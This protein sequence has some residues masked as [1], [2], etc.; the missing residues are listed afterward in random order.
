MSAVELSETFF[1]KMAGWEAMKQARS[2][3]AADRVLSSNWTPPLLKGVV[4]SGE[5]TY[6]SGFVIQSER[7]VENLCPCRESRQWGKIC[8]HSVAVGLH[9]LQPPS[10]PGPMATGPR[11][12]EKEENIPWIRRG[13]DADPRLEL[14]L[15]LPP[16]LEA[17]LAR[18]RLMICL[19]AVLQGRRL[20]LP[21]VPEKDAYQVEDAD[22]A[23]LEGLESIVG[24]QR[25]AGWQLS[26]ADWVRLLP[27]LSG[28]PRITLG[29]KTPVQVVDTPWA[30]PLDVHRTEE[31]ELVLTC[32][33]KSSMGTLLEGAWIYRSATFQPFGLPPSCARLSESAITLSRRELPLFL[34]R[35]WPALVAGG[36]VH[37]DF[38]P[39]DFVLDT[40]SPSFHLKL[41]GGLAMLDA[42]LQ[43]SYAGL[44]VEPGKVDGTSGLFLVDPA[45]VNA[46]HA[47]DLAAEQH[48]VGR[49]LRAGFKGPD[50]QGEWHLHDKEGVLQ[51][52]ATVFPHLENEWQV[53]MEERLTRS[54]ERNLERIEPRFQMRGSG[55]PWLELSISYETTRGTTLPP[56]E[57]QRLLRSGR[58]HSPLKN[59]KIVLMDTEAVEEF[60]EVLRDV[61]PQQNPSGYRIA[62]SQGGFIEA[63]IRDMGWRLQGE[64][65]PGRPPT[66]PEL[67]PLE[68]ILRPYQREGVAWLARLAANRFGG[69]LADEMGLGKT[70]QALAFL[71]HRV[72]QGNDDASGKKRPS[73][74]VC[75]TSLVSNWQAEAARF[76]PDLRVLVLHG[77]QRQG[78]FDHVP[79][80]DLVITSYALIRRD[81]EQYRVW[82]FDT[83][84]LDE[85]QHIKNRQTQNARAVKGVR[86]LNR[87]VLTGTPLE[88]SVLDLW[89]IF[90]FVMPGYL[91]SEKDFRERYEV[92]IVQG[93]DAAAQARLSRRIRPFLLRRRKQEVAADLPEK[94]EQVA[95]CELS[96]NQRSVYRQFLEAGNRDVTEAVN[97]QGFAR[98]RMLVLNTLLRLRQVCCDLRLL[99]VDQ[100]EP[101]ETSGKVELF[102]ELLEEV[103]DG[104]HRVLVFSQFVSL[105]S[106]LR[107]QFE[108]DG[109]EFCYL[110]GSTKDRAGVVR[111]FQ[112]QAHIP[113]F[114]IS[115]KAGGVGLNLTGADT[116][117]HFDPWWNPAVE[118]QATDRAHRIGQTR[119][120]TSYKLITRDTVEEKILKLQ[121]RKKVLLQGALGS[122]E[123]L[124]QAVQWEDVQALLG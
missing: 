47:R 41:E 11:P 100:G 16:N 112:T 87:L 64:V 23:L 109:V 44:E 78:L 3:V 92:C 17:S 10:K 75:P 55:T 101:S 85:A 69:I 50:K 57:I 88:N 66:C 15:V 84:I 89:S 49:L 31:G 8:A 7:D 35:D 9:H 40:L 14:H 107:E 62:S 83:A 58:N 54:T 95:Y 5:S 2:I 72:A 103:I 28:H 102:G 65:S 113:V 79:D 56:A 90:D 99:D 60:Q 29:R 105:L 22:R 74:V 81:A 32:R 63:S 48:A 61:D 94:L 91:G 43:C 76:T 121:E 93:K 25:S 124:A 13:S 34:H 120:V 18:G 114:L 39:D 30:P 123:D 59:G 45:R 73:L 116:V 97:R 4:Q 106:L 86:A 96:P 98:S 67:G 115:L 12:A 20:P 46:Y 104:G 108:A 36:G 1:S 51:F 70:L 33:D 52:F 24:G 37:A 71:Q 118:A 110:D 77:P 122:E 119:K 82:E 27:A 117:I 19:E 21:A 68:K 111:R 80:S 53:T 26:K 6:R 42:T 38:D